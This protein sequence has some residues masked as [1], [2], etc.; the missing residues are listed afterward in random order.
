M[1]ITQEEMNTG[2]LENAK[3]SLV[4][5]VVSVNQIRH[6]NQSLKEKSF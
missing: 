2:C 6:V 4:E 1:Q 3:F 5:I